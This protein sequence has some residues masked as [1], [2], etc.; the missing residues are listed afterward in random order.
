[1]QIGE[2][3]NL[4]L[5][6][7]LFIPDFLRFT[8]N[9]IY[10][11]TPVEIP[12][13]GIFTAWSQ[14]ILC[15]TNIIRLGQADGPFGL[16]TDFA[17]DGGKVNSVTFVC[18]L[19]QFLQILLDGAV[20]AAIYELAKFLRDLLSIEFLFGRPIY[21]PNL[22]I[23]ISDLQLTVDALA[24]VLASIIPPTFK[25]P[26]MFSA[27]CTVGYNGVPSVPCNGNP[28]NGQTFLQCSGGSACFANFLAAVIGGPL[29]A[30]VVLNN[31]YVM[32]RSVASVSCS[33]FFTEQDCANNGC[34]WSGTTC[35]APTNFFNITI[36]DDIVN[37]VVQVFE[38][39]FDAVLL[40]IY[41]LAVVLDCINCGSIYN[42]LYTAQPDPITWL[43]TCNGGG[44]LLR[45]GDCGTP[46]PLVFD[47]VVLILGPLFNVI[48]AFITIIVNIAFF[49]IVVVIALLAGQPDTIPTIATEIGANLAAAWNV[50]SMNAAYFFLQSLHLLNAYNQFVVF[51][52]GVFSGFCNGWND[53]VWILLD[54]CC[55][56][57]VP[58]D[59]HKVPGGCAGYCYGMQNIFLSNCPALLPIQA[60]P[61]PGTPPPVCSTLDLVT[62]QLV[63]QCYWNGAL[64]ENATL[65]QQAGISRQACIDNAN[66]L[67][68]PNECFLQTSS[69]T[70]QNHLGF[71]A[72]LCIDPAHQERYTQ[73][74]API[75][76]FPGCGS[77]H[78]Y[79]ACMSDV[80]PNGWAGVCYWRNDT[81]QCVT[82]APLCHSHTNQLDC[83]RMTHFCPQT[84]VSSKCPSN[85]ATIILNHLEN[86]TYRGIC[87][88]DTTNNLCV[89]TGP[90][91]SALSIASGQFYFQ[92]SWFDAG[93]GP[94][95]AQ[96]IS[97]AE[98]IDAV[99]SGNPAL[100][101][102][103]VIPLYN[104]QYKKRDADGPP[105]FNSPMGAARDTRR[106]AA[107]E[108]NFADHLK[109]VY[110]ASQ[111]SQAP[112]PP[113]GSPWPAGD[114]CAFIG[115]LDAST[116][117]GLLNA[118]EQSVVFDSAA[119]LL[120][121]LG[122]V[123]AA[124]S[125]DVNLMPPYA[126]LQGVPSQGTR[127]YGDMLGAGVCEVLFAQYYSL[128]TTYD[129]ADLRPLE[130]VY[131]ADCVRS[132]MMGLFIVHASGWNWLPPDIMSNWLAK[133]RLLPKV[134]LALRTYY[135]YQNDR[136]LDPT[137]VLS[138]QYQAGLVAEG[139][140][141]AYLANVTTPA[142]LAGV[143]A[144]QTLE[145]YFIC[146]GQTV[147]DM[148]IALDIAP[149]LGGLGQS[150]LGTAT[151]VLGKFAS[152]DARSLNLTDT[153]VNSTD[154]QIKS[155]L[156]SALLG[157]VGGFAQGVN[158]TQQLV[159]NA[160]QIKKR[161]LPAVKG[162]GGALVTIM[163]RAKSWLAAPPGTPTP[164]THTPKPTP[165]ETPIVLGPTGTPMG[166]VAQTSQI[167]F[168]KSG[169][170][171]G[172]LLARIAFRWQGLKL[173]VANNPVGIERRAK[174]STVYEH[175]AFTVNYLLFAD[176]APDPAARKAQL[177]ASAPPSVL[178]SMRT[179]VSKDDPVHAVDTIIGPLP[180]LTGVFN[181]G[182]DY[183]CLNCI[184]LDQFVGRVILLG[185]W[186]YIYFSGTDPNFWYNFPRAYATFQ[187]YAN[188]LALPESVVIVGDSAELPLKFPPN[189][190]SAMRYFGDASP[191]KLRF[192]DYEIFFVDI[193]DA[194]TLAITDPN[195]L[196]VVQIT[197]RILSVLFDATVS[198]IWTAS[199]NAAK[200]LG[201]VEPATATWLT[202]R[203]AG[204]QAAAVPPLG[205]TLSELVAKI[206]DQVRL[207][208][209]PSNPH[210]GSRTPQVWF[211]E[212]PL[213]LANL[214]DPITG[215]PAG[216][217]LFGTQKRFAIGE[218]I[219][220]S[221][222]V[223][224]FVALPLVMIV[225][226]TAVAI[227]L[228]TM[229]GLLVMLTLFLTITYNWSYNCFPAL[230]QPLGSDI[231][232]FTGFVLMP[233]CAF[234]L[235]GVY[236]G[237]YNGSSC[238]SCDAA[239][240]L[241]AL[242]CVNDLGFHNLYSNIAFMT[243]ALFPNLPLLL[244]QWGVPAVVANITNS[245][246]LARFQTQYNPANAD[247]YA[248]HQACNWI[249]TLIPNTTV[250]A[251]AGFLFVLS[252]PLIVLQY[253]FVAYVI[254]NALILFFLLLTI[255]DYMVFAASAGAYIE[256]YG[257]DPET[258]VEA[259][260][261]APPAPSTL[262]AATSV[263]AALRQAAYA[264]P[265]SQAVGV[266]RRRAPLERDA[267]GTELRVRQPLADVHV[268]HDEGAARHA[269][270]RSALGQF[271]G[272]Q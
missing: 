157:A 13:E 266:L 151:N 252:L 156:V 271:R 129:W 165:T 89:A 109:R 16:C 146:Q 262:P 169:K 240:N 54:I 201:L 192:Y 27:N 219:A 51:I 140:N 143:L 246:A 186:L 14:M 237:P 212:A 272:A 210:G 116:I 118:D 115:A 216:D 18:C 236:N 142:Q 136:A 145:S 224:V 172:P 126:P 144:N 254:Q 211:C 117:A 205:Q 214:T 234:I 258:D 259:P 203:R 29:V 132:Q 23:V 207:F 202:T 121:C 111:D 53:F 177:L 215:A 137:I 20:I 166:A 231:R 35:G 108:I 56:S 209:F 213:S 79:T 218:V 268:A 15:L 84:N 22:S 68:G 105:L 217:E 193:F 206:V 52:N 106:F 103:T 6:I 50:L 74:S 128:N 75:P 227:T 73:W 17:P 270:A 133:W 43:E 3:L 260:K 195:S 83:T 239:N 189:N 40:I 77:L 250:A 204:S 67:G 78:S 113:P 32:I 125:A 235:S 37:F 94:A 101:L 76:V 127:S 183:L 154:G 112:T 96:C 141:V 251:Y 26:I 88:F 257:T 187:W 93:Q 220:I 42:T 11:K 120:F 38:D 69:S 97:P 85:A 228:S 196:L 208:S 123:I 70:F 65:C 149:L 150:L 176:W 107:S 98:L 90:Y 265:F 184:Y 180:C 104:T 100:Y 162:I 87:T 45:C 63:P 256:T 225:P 114:S 46:E 130:R 185:K 59:K 200:T 91:Y 9:P 1:L 152:F 86:A 30:L 62:C 57:S 182:T 244:E 171:V 229:A 175:V 55:L 131:L 95:F 167:A 47:F 134:G 222:L 82:A 261:G 249:W 61:L 163:Q 158:A 194:V 179:Y 263:R 191:N 36:F 247:N 19:A 122:R 160:P 170:L 155:A 5:T 25:C 4:L 102:N 8:D 223:V 12:L 232:N 269:A 138:A 7:M 81:Q 159:Q 181:I 2:L 135:T 34:I 92:C 124:T 148:H 267:E 58:T 139:L 164:I 99:E 153:L 242:S 190:H 66:L 71:T 199:V 161:F 10:R 168:D 174:I 119:Q 264:S 173:A 110:L 28:G 188:Y 238:Y 31:F 253:L 80:Y 245:G 243:V 230:P 72:T 147:V 241:T 255:Y 221:V 49:L 60:V 39:V 44:P 178:A 226:S 64:C 233:K 198:Q 33:N 248:A 197:Q 24:C 41:T 21:L 48:T